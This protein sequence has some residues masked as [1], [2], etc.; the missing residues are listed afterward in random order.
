MSDRPEC[1]ILVGLPGSGKTSFFRERFAATHHHVSKDLLRNNRR[2]SRRQTQLIAEALAGGRS[3]VV[4]NVNGRAAER[5]PIIE[6]ARRCGAA[7]VGYV[8]HPSVAD[9]LRRNRAR[10][11]AARVPDVAIFAAR[12][13]FD[14]PAWHEGFDRLFEVTL[15]EP[16]RQFEIRPYPTQ[17]GADSPRQSSGD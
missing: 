4:D 5:A 11:G 2:P 1:V 14:E 7:T 10:T 8:F 3:V 6:T 15:N 12:K 17:A 13:H 16:E 9:A